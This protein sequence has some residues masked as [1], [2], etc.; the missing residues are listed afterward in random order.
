MENNKKRNDTLP[1]LAWIG[2]L[3]LWVAVLTIPVTRTAFEGATKAHPYIMG[4]IK[5]FILGTMGDILGSRIVKGYFSWPTNVLKKAVVWGTIGM[6]ITLLF[7]LFN[8]GVQ[9][10]MKTGYLPFDNSPWRTFFVAFFSSSAMN[11]VFGPTMYAYH[12][13]MD[14]WID[15]RGAKKGKVTLKEVTDTNDWYSLVSFSWLK[16]LPFVWI[17]LHTGVFL[18]PPNFRIVA[19]AF[20]GIVLGVLV[21]LSKKKK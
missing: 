21:A 18:L 5:F 9:A 20:L 17:P 16:T 14:L 12:K 8:H 7:P 13:L 11:L 10:A 6:M 3:L 2:V 19:S 4:F 15:L 1:L